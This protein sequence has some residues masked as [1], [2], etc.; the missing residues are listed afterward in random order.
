[1][2]KTTLRSGRPAAPLGCRE[3]S[4]SRSAMPVDDRNLLDLVAGAGTTDSAELSS[5]KPVPDP[6]Q[7]GGWS[8]RVR[9]HLNMLG[10]E[11]LAVALLAR[12]YLAVSTHAPLLA[13]A[14]EELG[15][16]ITVVG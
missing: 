9:R 2:S 4:C 16:D 5:E 10:A 11:A 6:S 7:A 15:P 13:S 12:A 14:A 8:C 1:M 3:C